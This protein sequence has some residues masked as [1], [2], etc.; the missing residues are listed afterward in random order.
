[1]GEQENKSQSPKMLDGNRKGVPKR[2]GK[3]ETRNKP[4]KR[5]GKRK[6]YNY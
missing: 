3:T 6:G 2:K 5:N 4:E 1:V